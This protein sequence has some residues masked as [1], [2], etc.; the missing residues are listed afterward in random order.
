MT[1]LIKNLKIKIENGFKEVPLGTEAK[2]VSVPSNILTGVTVK[3]V[4][5]ALKTINTKIDSTDSKVDQ[6]VDSINQKID[7]VS[8]S[9]NENLNTAFEA[10]KNRMNAADTEIKNMI[11]IIPTDAESVMSVIEETQN[12]ISTVNRNL[13][14]VTEQFNSDIANLNRGLTTANNKIGAI[15]DQFSSVMDA[16]KN[17]NI[18]VGIDADKDYIWTDD[19]VP[20]FDRLDSLENHVGLGL[21]NPTNS[22]D[23]KV[24]LIS[25]DV[26]QLGNRVNLLEKSGID[27]SDVEMRLMS[28]ESTHDDMREAMAKMENVYA[29]KTGEFQ[30]WKDQ[31]DTAQIYLEQELQDIKD[32]IAEIQ[33]KLA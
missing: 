30:T 20:V 4:E 29:W 1:E 26:V 32:A 27:L 33:S 19:V 17:I 8:E 21:T 23:N 12:D 3:N 16:V 24:N 22:L 10:L 25:Q 28:L 5:K 13:A 18:A 11:G 9:F 7:T 31:T 2:Y 15:P 6:E 14:Q